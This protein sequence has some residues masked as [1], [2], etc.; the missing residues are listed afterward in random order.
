MDIDGDAATSAS[1]ARATGAPLL[2]G[3]VLNLL[4]T[5]LHVL[6]KSVHRIATSEQRDPRDD[7]YGKKLVHHDHLP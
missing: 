2:L 1:N 6:S 4:A 5:A 3:L 7:S